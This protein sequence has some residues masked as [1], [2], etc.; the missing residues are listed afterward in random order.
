MSL[1][2][3]GAPAPAA[4]DPRPHRAFRSLDGLVAALRV[5]EAARERERVPQPVPAVNE[6]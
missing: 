1:E 5:V 4:R 6:A 2:L 3:E